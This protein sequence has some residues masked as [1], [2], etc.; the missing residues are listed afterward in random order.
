[1]KRIAFTRPVA[2]LNVVIGQHLVNVEG[3]ILFGNAKPRCLIDG[4]DEC[5]QIGVNQGRQ[6]CRVD[7]RRHQFRNAR[8]DM[9]RPIVPIHGPF[10]QVNGVCFM[11]SKPR[12]ARVAARD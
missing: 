1:M 10:G 8:A 9:Q 3:A 2:N 12:G 11:R 7:C 5:A 6:R 4:V